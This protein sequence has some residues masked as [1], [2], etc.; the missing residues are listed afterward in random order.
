M[1]I[2]L[3]GIIFISLYGTLDFLSSQVLEIGT[4]GGTR[5]LSQLIV[6]QARQLEMGSTFGP[7]MM[8]ANFTT[9]QLNLQT[10]GANFLNLV[11]Q[12][13]LSKKLKSLDL[14]N[15]WNSPMLNLKGRS[16]NGTAYPYT[17]DATTMFSTFSSSIQALA[18]LNMSLYRPVGGSVPVSSLYQN[19]SNI[20]H[21]FEGELSWSFLLDNGPSNVITSIWSIVT[22]SVGANDSNV[23]YQQAIFITLFGVAVIL[24]LLITMFSVIPSYWKL[25]RERSAVMSLY[26]QITGEVLSET[27][28]TV[29][30][31]Y[32]QLNQKLQLNVA[33]LAVNGLDHAP[34]GHAKA[35]GNQ[36]TSISIAS[37]LD[38]EL[39]GTEMD[40]EEHGFSRNVRMFA[41]LS[42]SPSWTAL[43]VTYCASIAVLM[44]LLF[45][46]M[47]LLYLA[48]VRM[49]NASKEINYGGSRRSYTYK[50][51]VLAQEMVRKD[52]YVWPDMEELRNIYM[53][54]LQQSYY[55]HQAVNH[56]NASYRLGGCIGR[57]EPM[58]KLMLQRNCT[59]SSNDCLSLNEMYALYLRHALTLYYTP[60][61]SLTFSHPSF[62]LM[63]SFQ[64]GVFS[65]NLDLAK[66][67]F[68]DEMIPVIQN[69][70]IWEQVLS[71]VSLS[72]AMFLLAAFHFQSNRLREHV[73]A[74]K[75]L[76]NMVPYEFIAK[77]KPMYKYLKHAKLPHVLSAKEMEEEELKQLDI[78]NHTVMSRRN[79]QVKGAKRKGF[80]WLTG[81][82]KGV[83]ELSD[84][85]LM[86]RSDEYDEDKQ[87]LGASPALEVNRP[88]YQSYVPQDTA[89]GGIQYGPD[90][91]S[92]KEAH[93]KAT[94]NQEAMSSVVEPKADT[95]HLVLSDVSLATADSDTES[96]SDPLKE[97]V[98][99]IIQQGQAPKKRRS[100]SISRSPSGH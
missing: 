72:A 85:K 67:L 70:I 1:F 62:R 75:H 6:Y 54:D 33:K 99:G 51:M 65:R 95:P 34:L 86:R 77:N 11:S 46:A 7:S 79:S 93:P 89:L 60:L 100:V 27:Q 78:Q 42:K 64:S 28:R 82:R 63:K 35:T 29:K 96:K 44:A 66:Q 25:K 55:V 36:S 5:R 45:S 56:G 39:S 37:S 31:S 26:F 22:A 2:L 32:R 9:T 69:T 50:L 98:K 61:Q 40:D 88:P 76:L 87:E 24:P 43:M 4:M 20:T 73:N 80:G 71:V 53:G 23:R 21:T 49:E 58:D 10:N 92:V 81:W 59:T 3:A 17:S 12:A 94:M 18:S 47:Y 48:S 68:S 74:A 90:R 41:L 57:Y 83:A 14:D 52:Y 84:E 38:S 13:K 15:S 30:A 16:P 19:A 8:D 97:S 91:P